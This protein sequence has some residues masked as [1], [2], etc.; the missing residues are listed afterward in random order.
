MR[1]RANLVMAVIANGA[2]LSRI[3]DRFRRMPAQSV[4]RR[5]A[6]VFDA[7]IVRCG[8]VFAWVAVMFSTF[9]LPR[10]RRYLTWGESP[11]ACRGWLV[12]FATFSALPQ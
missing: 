5:T 2:G 3:A 4:K 11:A 10:P 9:A 7:G 12:L 8:L 6:R 1:L